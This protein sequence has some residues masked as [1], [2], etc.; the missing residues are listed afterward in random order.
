MAA[1]LISIDAMVGHTPAVIAQ[2]FL[3]ETVDYMVCIS[4]S[5]IL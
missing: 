1:G 3:V 4:L 5:F 2:E